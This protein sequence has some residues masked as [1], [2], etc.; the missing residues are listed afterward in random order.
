MELADFF[1]TS[2]NESDGKPDSS[3]PLVGLKKDLD[4]YR[5]A[6]KEVSEEII[7]EG[8]SEYP[9]FVAHQHEVSLGEL[10]LDKNELGTGWSV[11]ASTLEEF[12]ERGVIN[13]ERKARFIKHYK[14]PD[15]F[16]CLFVIVPQGANFVFYPYQD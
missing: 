12:V 3:S 10:I 7:R 13:A 2:Q 14:N 15:Q 6:I 1:S 5:E 16:M 9:V 4:F 11:H 8:L